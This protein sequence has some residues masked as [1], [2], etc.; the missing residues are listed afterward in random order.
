VTINFYAGDSD[1]D[2]DLELALP[3]SM[4]HQIIFI[5]QISSGWVILE[6]QLA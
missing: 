3:E 2:A 6:A 5:S 4:L 1:K